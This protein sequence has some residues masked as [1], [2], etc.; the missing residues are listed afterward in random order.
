MPMG[1]GGGEGFSLGAK[2]LQL[3]LGCWSTQSEVIICM[4]E[5]AFVCS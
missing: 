1:F 5:D 2:V 4:E 3:V